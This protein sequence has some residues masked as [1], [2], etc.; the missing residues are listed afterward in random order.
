MR[1]IATLLLITALIGCRT[2]IG[3][4]PVVT[5]D[6]EQMAT[7]HAEKAIGLSVVIGQASDAFG[8][9]GQLSEVGAGFLNGI[10]QLAAA[11]MAPFGGLFN[12]QPPPQ[13]ITIHLPDN[14]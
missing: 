7:V 5:Y 14:E 13:N 9:G 1:I 6:A 4:T 3:S 10:A 8:K 2:T 11:M 12:Q